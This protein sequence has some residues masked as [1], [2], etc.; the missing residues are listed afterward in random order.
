MKAPLFLPFKLHPIC[1]GGKTAHSNTI[2]AR[3]WVCRTLPTGDHAKN[4]DLLNSQLQ[5]ARKLEEMFGNFFELG[6]LVQFGVNFCNL[7]NILD[8]AR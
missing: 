2:R 7:I 6:P 4:F 5:A 8:V 3:A 1:W